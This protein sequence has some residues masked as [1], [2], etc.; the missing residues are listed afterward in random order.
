MRRLPAASLLVL[1]LA[2]A[3]SGQKPA[4]S[5]STPTT[6]AG[7]GAPPVGVPLFY[8]GESRHPGWYDGYDWTGR[9]RAT[10][11]LTPPDATASLYQSPDGSSFIQAPGGGKGGY[12]PGTRFLDRVGKPLPDISPGVQFHDIMWA[13]DSTQACTL[14]FDTRQWRVGLIAPGVPFHAGHA[15]AVDSFVTT[16]GVIAIRLA[17]CS[18]RHDVA[19]LTYSFAQYPTYVWIVRL[20]DGSIL[21]REAFERN[22]IA[23]IA[24]SPDGKLLAESSNTSVGYVQPG[25]AAQTT[26]TDASTG[27]N[28]ATLPATY[29]VIA[30]S[31]DDSVALVTTSPWVSGA[32]THLALIK[33]GTGTT[34]WRYDGDKEYGGRWIQPGGSSVAVILQSPAD[35]SM[36]VAVDVVIVHADGSSSK[37]A[38]TY[39]RA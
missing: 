23:D 38:G 24:A 25:A 34:V 5:V 12:G 28:I 4:S 37:L 1:I 26:I 33:V 11:K 13:D 20:S 2:A 18:P 22:A 7:Y 30:F 39:V 17:A 19:V 31:A 15:V 29:D 32:P 14:D 35:Q 8:L 6:F 10:I 9:P 21:R 16:S 36:H 3:C 27:A